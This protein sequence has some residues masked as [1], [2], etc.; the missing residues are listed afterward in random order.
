[1][2]N[3]D[4]PSIVLMI[5]L[6]IVISYFVLSNVMLLETGPVYNHLNKLYMALLMGS[7]MGFIAA[8]SMPMSSQTKSKLLIISVIVTIGLIWVIRKQV[9]IDD[10]NFTKSMGE[11]HEMGIL[12]AREIVQK[13]N[14]EF[15]KELAQNIIKTQQKEIDEMVSFNLAQ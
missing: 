3:H 4:T 8:L 15:I 7:T 6:S 9:F 14:N 13:T 5:I 11:H 12:M 10:K 2:K 1:M